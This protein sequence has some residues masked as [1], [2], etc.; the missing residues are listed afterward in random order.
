MVRQI[1]LRMWMGIGIK[2]ISGWS[3]YHDAEG[4]YDLFSRIIFWWS[5]GDQNYAVGYNWSRVIKY[6]EIMIFFLCCRNMQL[7][8]L[9]IKIMQIFSLC[10]C[11]FVRL[12]TTHFLSKDTIPILLE[13]FLLRWQRSFLVTFWLIY[14]IFWKLLPSVVYAMWVFS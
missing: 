5:L 12:V 11:D 9:L 2:L 8:A 10:F 4:N 1:L 6:L 7:L 14:W 3:S 13:K